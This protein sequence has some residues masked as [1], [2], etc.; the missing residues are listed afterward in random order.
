MIERVQS[1]SRSQL[2]H[3]QASKALLPGAS[4]RAREEMGKLEGQLV[5]LQE[6]QD[7]QR[8]SREQS[9]YCRCPF[10]VVLVER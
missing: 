8:G 2:H 4:P 7:Q 6:R 9:T 3:A 10:L 1:F 5:K